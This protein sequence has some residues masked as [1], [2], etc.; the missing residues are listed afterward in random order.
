MW[1]SLFHLSFNFNRRQFML[2]K[3]YNNQHC[4]STCVKSLHAFYEKV[5]SGAKA[6]TNFQ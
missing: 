1:V 3:Q 5:K 6:T 2:E 4:V